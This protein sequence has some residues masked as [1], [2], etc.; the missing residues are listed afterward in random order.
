M[1]DWRVLK[2]RGH[3]WRQHRLIRNRSAYPSS[4]PYPPI[5]RPQKLSHLHLRAH[6]T[7]GPLSLRDEHASREFLLPAHDR[8]LAGR[9]SPLAT[10][11]G[12][13]ISPSSNP[14][15]LP[16]PKSPP[17]GRTPPPPGATLHPPACPLLRVRRPRRPRRQC[18]TRPRLLPLEGSSHGERRSA[19]EG[20]GVL[21]LPLWFRKR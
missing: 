8:P 7:C 21:L 4:L 12:R 14:P 1:V 2:R 18:K 11:V 5:N 16:Q 15:I 10:Q 19:A 6:W 9:R 3:E 13:G 20:G 17:P